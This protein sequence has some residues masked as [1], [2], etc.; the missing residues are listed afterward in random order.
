[1]GDTPDA[2]MGASF[3]VRGV[4]CE[5]WE[6]NVTITGSSGTSHSYTYEYYFPVTSWQGGC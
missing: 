1:M 4:K 3:M 6:R 2:Y 5:K